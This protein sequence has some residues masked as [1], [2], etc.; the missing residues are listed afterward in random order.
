M[1]KKT[2]WLSFH[3]STF[4]YTTGNSNSSKLLI[5]PESRL[6]HNF[7]K[8]SSSSATS[9]F[10]SHEPMTGSSGYFDLPTK[11]L[12]TCQ[13]TQGT[14]RKAL[15]PGSADEDG[16][17]LQSTARLFYTNYEDQISVF[18]GNPSRRSWTC[19]SAMRSATSLKA[20]Q[21]H[22]SSE[23][24]KT[25]PS[26]ASSHQLLRDDPQFFSFTRTERITKES[27][28]N[29]SELHSNSTKLKLRRTIFTVNPGSGSASLHPSCEVPTLSP[30]TLSSPKRKT[31]PPKKFI[32]FL[33]GF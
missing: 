2:C 15:M 28:K 4:N 32:F 1:F 18:L 33:Q 19:W 25:S 11:A 24:R 27:P 7:M 3:L 22:T 30:S 16:H 8:Q 21:N 14:L 13:A 26:P 29:P 20:I 17:T 6:P 12:S 10:V 5:S 31:L 9:H 23:R